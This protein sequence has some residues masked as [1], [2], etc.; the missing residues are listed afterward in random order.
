MVGLFATSSSHAVSEILVKQNY[1]LSNLQVSCRGNS[2][3]RLQLT[4]EQYKHF[5]LF[6]VQVFKLEVPTIELPPAAIISQDFKIYLFTCVDRFFGLD[7][8][9][10]VAP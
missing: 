7:G 9:L 5:L 8:G 1:F 3:R 10:P 2:S 6:D 4:L